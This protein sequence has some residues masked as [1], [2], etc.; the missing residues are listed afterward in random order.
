[1]PPVR[2]IKSCDAAWIGERGVAGWRV[3]A[4]KSLLAACWRS[5]SKQKV[6]WNRP[7][8]GKNKTMLVRSMQGEGAVRGNW[9]SNC[10]LN[11]KYCSVC[12]CMDCMTVES[13]LVKYSDFLKTLPLLPVPELSIITCSYCRLSNFSRLKVE[14]WADSIFF[15]GNSSSILIL[16]LIF[17]VCH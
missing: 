17:F 9:R 16:S 12:C 7:F 2:V 5:L 4:G 3:S 8:H 13:T 14:Y 15:K 10:K 11:Q 6:W 1:M